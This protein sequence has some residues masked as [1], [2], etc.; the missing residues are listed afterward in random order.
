MDPDF[1]VSE[2]Y[3]ILSI[4]FEKQT[5]HNYGYTIKYHVQVQVKGPGYLG[6]LSFH[7]KIPSPDAV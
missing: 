7:G 3:T 1:V 2:V 5:I 4:L 6:F